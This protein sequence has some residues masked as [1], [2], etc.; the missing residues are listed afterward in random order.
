MLS[1]SSFILFP[2]FP[3]TRLIDFIIA[4]MRLLVTH[5]DWKKQPCDDLFSILELRNKINEVKLLLPAAKESAWMMERRKHLIKIMR[6][7]EIFKRFD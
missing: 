4:K 5:A 6:D 7:N 2:H 1:F 3:V